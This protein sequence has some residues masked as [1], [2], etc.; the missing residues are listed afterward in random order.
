MAGFSERFGKLDPYLRT[1]FSWLLEVKG[2]D[3]TLTGFWALGFHLS[4]IFM[5]AWY[6]YTSG[7]GIVSTETNRGFYLLFTSVLVYLIFPASRRAPRHR[8]SLWDLTC[9]VLISLSLGYWI[10]QYVQ[11]AIFRVSDP[12]QWDLIMGGIA[13]VMILETS[14]RVLG[15]AMV[16]LGSIFLL[17]LYFGP[18]LP[19]KLSHSG[20]SITRIIEFTYSTQEALF[21]V[22]T[23]TFATFVFPFMIFG[24]FLERS[25][26]GLFFMDLATAL[27]GRWR[28]GPA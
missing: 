6:M 21:G 20:M 8:P 10:D 22:I 15:I 4:A 26:A 3:R 12:S 24:A 17:Q 5:A 13:I 14:R 19:G 23:T 16:I 28:G 7:F 11:Y 9:V 2:K 1:H 27:T 25:G 18:L